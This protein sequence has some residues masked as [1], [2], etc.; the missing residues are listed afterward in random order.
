MEGTIPKGWTIDGT[1]PLTLLTGTTNAGTIDSS[2]SSITDT[3]SFTNSGTLDLTGGT[4]VDVAHLTNASTGL[5]ESG[6]TSGRSVPVFAGGAGTTAATFDNYGTLKVLANQGL[7]VGPASCKA[8]AGED[9]VTEPGSV[10]TVST[11]TAPNTT[12][13]MVCGGFTVDGGTI[14]AAPVLLRG[15]RPRERHL[16]TQPSAGGRRVAGRARLQGSGTSFTDSIPK[17]W[18]LYV[19]YGGHLSMPNGDGNNGTLIFTGGEIVDPG[20][21]VNNGVI[22]AIGGQASHTIPAFVNNGT[23]TVPSGQVFTLHEAT[24]ANDGTVELDHGF[25]DVDGFTQSAG[26]TLALT[27]VNGNVGDV[28]SFGQH[29]TVGGT[30]ALSTSGTLP[31]IGTQYTIVTAAATI[32]GT[33]ATVTGAIAGGGVGYTLTYATSKRRVILTVVSASALRSLTAGGVTPLTPTTPVPGETVTGSFTVTNTGTQKVS[34]SWV[35]SVYLASGPATTYQSGDALLERIPHSGTLTPG[36]HYTGH[37]TAQLPVVPAGPYHLIVVPDSED[38]VATTAN[39]QQADS[40]EFTVAAIPT[41]SPGTPVHAT[42]KAGQDEY[43]QVAVGKGSDVSVAVTTPAA[44]DADVYGALGNIPGPSS[45][46]LSSTPNTLVPSVVLPKSSAGTWYLDIHG[47]AGAGSGTAITITP[48]LVGLAVSSVSP[49]K[50]GA[51]GPA[52]VTLQGSGF[53]PGMKVHLVHGSTSISATDVQLSSSTTAFATFT[54]TGAA[55]GTYDVVVTSG[56]T[57]VTVHGAVQVQSTDLTT[58]GLFTHVGGA[59]TLRYGWFGRAS[60]CSSSTRPVTTS[61]SL[62]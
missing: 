5:I 54:L 4:H 25:L 37:I 44:G 17:G 30:L 38:L 1:G 2:A 57:P 7:T 36:A 41:L 34:G 48:T 49:A 21:F 51:N 55:T 50:L 52:T 3:G 62:W 61:T 43:Y 58:S 20:T 31:T 10:I 32:S 40:A 45:F 42:I 15:Q 18:T 16:H 53:D 60:G 59:G 24:F 29:T 19:D 28:G 56:A 39:D 13:T 6:A 23:L 35:D 27:V 12:F 46:T 47:D 9:L 11:K 33:F 22:H 8:T 14:A 26:G